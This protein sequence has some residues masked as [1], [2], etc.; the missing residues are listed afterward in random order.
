MIWVFDQY[1]GGVRSSFGN[2][3][4]APK[5]FKGKLDVGISSKHMSV[6]RGH[7][8]ILAYKSWYAWDFV[9]ISVGYFGVDVT[10]I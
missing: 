10:L 9:P 6:F 8:P 7:Y 2:C 5:T 4:W 3:F 1:S